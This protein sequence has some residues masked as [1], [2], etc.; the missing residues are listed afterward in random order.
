[1]GYLRDLIKSTKHAVK[2]R[3]CRCAY[4][5]NTIFSIEDGN[6]DLKE[7]STFLSPERVKNVTGAENSNFP[8]EKMELFCCRCGLS[9]GYKLNNISGLMGKRYYIRVSMLE[10]SS[11]MQ[12]AT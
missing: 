3:M 9:L 4:C 10:L 5:G 8:S 12:E 7:N 11:N 6:F 2:N 1:M